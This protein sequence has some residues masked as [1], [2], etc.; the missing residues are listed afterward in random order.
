MTHAS[1]RQK[2]KSKKEHEAAAEF[3][4]SEVLSQT[5][6]M[7]RRFLPVGKRAESRPQK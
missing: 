7:N 4:K 2:E 3:R 1:V 5:H 6:E